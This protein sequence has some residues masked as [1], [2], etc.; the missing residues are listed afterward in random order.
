MD[1]QE[2]E[3]RSSISWSAEDGFPRSLSPAKPGPV[4]AAS[5]CDRRPLA[6][7]PAW[8]FHSQTRT[9][10]CFGGSGAGVPNAS[11]SLNQPC[12]QHM[13]HLGVGAEPEGE[14][15]DRED[16]DGQIT[17]ANPNFIFRFNC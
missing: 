5:K 2:F 11:F 13:C 8:G 12:T 7:G 15:R 4:P 16:R 3:P 9:V 6:S 17:G 1:I 14:S 10:F